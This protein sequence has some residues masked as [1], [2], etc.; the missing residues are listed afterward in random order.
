MDLVGGQR[1][2]VGAEGVHVE[3]D[4]SGGLHRIAVKV[5]AALAAHAGH[6]GHRL[7]DAGLVVDQHHGH[8]C[9]V[10]AEGGDHRAG[11]DNAARRRG[12][13]RHLMAAS[14]QLLQRFEHGGGLDGRCDNV[15]KP[16]CGHGA[17]DGGVVRLSAA[18]GEDD[19]AGG[20]ADQG[21]DRLAGLF[22]AAPSRLAFFVNG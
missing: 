8:E 14:L 20:R 9:G 22:Q 7:N 21:R 2:S 6:A 3:I 15:M 11:L 13:N 18:A 1:Q 5:D 10:L 12:H 16:S 4:L 19:F 17:K